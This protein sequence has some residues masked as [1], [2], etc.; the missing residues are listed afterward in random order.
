M[1]RVRN[2]R[3]SKFASVMVSSCGRLAPAADEGQDRIVWNAVS[4]GSRSRLTLEGRFAQ[5]PAATLLT[6][7]RRV[8]NARHPGF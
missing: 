1:W 8:E 4:G 7:S 3:S 6:G 5:A 2:G